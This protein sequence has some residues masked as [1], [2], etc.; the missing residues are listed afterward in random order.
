MHRTAAV[1]VSAML[2]V[3]PMARAQPSGMPTDIEWKLAELGAAINPAE[4]AKLY[5]PLQ[6]TEPYQGI[7]VR[8]S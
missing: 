7:K 4:A 2:L 6:E 3:A 1:V 5:A 8:R